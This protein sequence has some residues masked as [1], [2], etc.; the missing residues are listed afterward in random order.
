[1]FGTIENNSQTQNIYKYLNKKTSLV[2]ENDLYFK[3]S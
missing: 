2:S 3:I 1:M